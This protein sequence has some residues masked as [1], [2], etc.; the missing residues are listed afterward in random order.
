V[1]VRRWEAGA[2]F[3]GVAFAAIFVFSNTAGLGWA[4]LTADALWIVTRVEI[5]ERH[6][7]AGW[8]TTQRGRLG[9]A[10]LLLLFGIYSAAIWSFFLIGH[11]LGHRARAGIVAD[12]ALAGL[13]FML[14]GELRRSGDETLNW[15]VGARAERRTGT[16]LDTYRARGW[17]VLHGYKRDWGGDIDHIVCGSAGAYAIETKSYGFR[18]RDVRQTAINAWWLRERL[19][20]RWVTGILCVDE[21]RVPE[22]HGKIW[23][24]GQNHL[25]DFISRQHNAVIDP[26]V[27]RDRLAKD[28]NANWSDGVGQAA[29]S[30]LRGRRTRRP[31]SHNGTGTMLLAGKTPDSDG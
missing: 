17:L 4:L 8:Y 7:V 14:L 31:R 20:V 15:I 16:L 25:L 2:A 26:A 27:A 13:C 19:G 18:S 3:V 1:K 23:A 22:Q 5:V 10:K 29:L 11:D 6:D 9:V 30:W 28:P 21:D 24:V 12:F